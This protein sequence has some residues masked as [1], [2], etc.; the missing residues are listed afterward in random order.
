MEQRG[1]VTRLLRELSHGGRDALDQLFPLVYDELHQIAHGRLRHEQP[2]HTLD[3]SALV[4]EVY[5]K[6]ADL[7]RMTWQN[8]V[9]FLAVAA[10]AMR[11]LLVNHAMSKQ[12]KKR[13]GRRRQVTLDEGILMADQR[14]AEF[15]ALDDALARLEEIDARHARVVE[16]RFFGGMSIEETAEVLGVSPATVKR[17]W[18]MA[19]AWLTRE[20]EQ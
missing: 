7:D 3:T 12:A 11:R 5:I 9:H 8:R 20:L 14:S 15:L 18:R 4:H 6:L 2:G 16:C 10:Q 13:G 19:R 17:D 1:E